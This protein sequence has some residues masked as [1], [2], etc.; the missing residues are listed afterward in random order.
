MYFRPTKLLEKL[1]P[2]YE[3]VLLQQ[4][5]FDIN[6]RALISWRLSFKLIKNSIFFDIALILCNHESL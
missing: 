6:I 2:N 4:I 3:R 1:Q 5:R